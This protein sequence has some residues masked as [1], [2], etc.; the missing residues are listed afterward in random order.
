MIVLKIVIEP[1]SMQTCLLWRFLPTDKWQ[2]CYETDNKESHK[3]T[4]QYTLLGI[5]TH[6]DKAD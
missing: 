5:Y 6:S 1:G 2:L 3:C 4:I